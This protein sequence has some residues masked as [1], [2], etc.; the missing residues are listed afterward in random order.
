MKIQNLFWKFI[1]RLDSSADV[2][3]KEGWSARKLTA[4]TMTML[5]VAVVLIWL[6]YAY[7]QGKWEY[8]LEVLILLAS[9][10]AAC[11]GMT[12]FQYMNKNKKDEKDPPANNSDT[13]S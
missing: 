11:L 4:F 12:T 8:M 2:H 3:S 1:Q 5:I 7:K 9:V 13:P 10:I 6:R